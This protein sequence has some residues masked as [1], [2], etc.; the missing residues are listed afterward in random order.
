MRY[1]P[2][3]RNRRSI[4]LPS[5]DYAAP[6][7]YFITI[8]AQDHECMF[9]EVEAG[10]VVLNEYGEIVRECWHDLPSHYDNVVLDACVVMPNHVHGII[11][12][13]GGEVGAGLKPAPTMRP[14]PTGVQERR[15]HG[16]PEIVRGLKTFSSRRINALRGTAGTPVWQR[17][18][19][20]HVVRDEDGLSRIRAYIEDNPR[21]WVE[22][23]YHPSIAP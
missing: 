11:V 23:E 10:T 15:R 12:L 1:D 17:N 21:R 14:A 22:D 7:A 13:A 8:C 18:Y 2:F 5:H 6:G 9:G 16:L 19:Y 3:R 20:E 4:R